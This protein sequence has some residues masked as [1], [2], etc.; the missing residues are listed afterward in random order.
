[1]KRV[2]EIYLVVIIFTIKTTKNGHQKIKM[3]IKQYY[4]AVKTPVIR[5]SPTDIRIGTSTT[6]DECI[7]FD[8]L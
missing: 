2:K 1:M 4:N 8:F 6:S 5:P 7:N 3:K